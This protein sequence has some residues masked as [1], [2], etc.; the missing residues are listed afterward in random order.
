MA[1]PRQRTNAGT[2]VAQAQAFPWSCKLQTLV[3]YNASSAVAYVQLHDS[4]VA[5]V[6]A[7]VP[8]F[9]IPVPANRVWFSLEIALEFDNGLTV[10]LSTTENTFTSAGANMAY[11]VVSAL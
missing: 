2:L 1:H 11:A 5:L 4:K 6:G 3:G 9:V 7:E 8:L 10:A